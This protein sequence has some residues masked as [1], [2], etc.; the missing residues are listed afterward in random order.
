MILDAAVLAAI[1]GVVVST[2]TVGSTTAQPRP[3]ALMCKKC[4]GVGG[5]WPSGASAATNMITCSD[6]AGRGVPPIPECELR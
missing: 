2:S 5:R 3:L 1:S 6:C 4:Y